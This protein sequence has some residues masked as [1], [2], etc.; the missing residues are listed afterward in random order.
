M[1]RSFLSD[2]AV[3][4]ASREFVCVRLATYESQAER[5]VLAEIYVGGSGDVE[6][7]TFAILEPD[8]RTLMS[9][10]AR[11]TRQVFGSPSYMA[12]YMEWAAEV[13][14][15]HDDPTPGLPTTAN[16]RLG[17]N[18]AA[19]DGL[20]LV[21]V[22]GDDALAARV[23]VLAWGPLLGR[24]VFAR[25]SA[26]ED[27]GAIEGNTSPGVFVVQPGTYGQTGHVLQHVASNADDLPAQVLAG[28][29]TH[30]TEAKTRDHVHTGRRQGVH[31]DT[32]IPVTDPHAPRR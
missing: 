18:I 24:C 13:C 17:V 25:V 32:Q 16:V 4:A 14:D 30:R 31:W 22:N 12:E 15:G 20:P 28:V 7:T 10:A 1:D 2:P 11:A 19:C 3:I 9:R 26:E 8:G 23:A 21:V 27:L 29:A 5:D 6:N